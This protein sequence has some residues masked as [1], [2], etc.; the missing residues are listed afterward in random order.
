M[1]SKVLIIYEYQILFE[2]LDEIKES[3][4]FKIIQSKKNNYNEIKS[5]PKIN[6]I[7]ISKEKTENIDNCLILENTPIK[8]EKLLEIININFLKKQFSSQSNIKIGKYNLDLNSRKIT[9]KDK[10]LDLTE[11][12]TSLIIFINDKTNVT[13]KELQKNVWD[14]SPSLETHT[15]ETHIYRLR[16]KMNDVFGDESFIVN[17]KNGYSIN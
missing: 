8:L 4:N 5:D 16:K 17:Y 1:N 13:V 6:Y 3:L 7:T 14:Y 9:F 15:V 10:S 12:E 2:I 11:R